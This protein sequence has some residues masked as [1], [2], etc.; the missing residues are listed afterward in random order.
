VS[1]FQATQSS[2]V[3]Q[4][5]QVRCRIWPAMTSMDFVNPLGTRGHLQTYASDQ[6]PSLAIALGVRQEIQSCKTNPRRRQHFWKV[7]IAICRYHWIDS[8]YVTVCQLLFQ[9]YLV[10]IYHDWIYVNYC[11]LTWQLFSSG[12]HIPMRKN[13]GSPARTEREGSSTQTCSI[14][15]R[16]GFVHFGTWKS[17]ENLQITGFSIG[18]SSYE[19]SFPLKWPWI[20][21]NIRNL[22]FFLSIMFPSCHFRRHTLFLDE[23]I[24]NVM[25][26][27]TLLGVPFMKMCVSD[28]WVLTGATR[29]Q[30]PSR[31]QLSK[32][33][34]W[35][36]HVCPRG[37][38]KHVN[39]D[40]QKIKPNWNTIQFERCP[41]TLW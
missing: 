38:P 23:A 41:F 28:F 40:R 3:H 36:S 25:T 11:Q 21:W 15:W 6:A 24:W 27:L 32:E 31:P 7:V 8:K 19:S 39:V 9:S 33:N 34:Q 26:F 14:S 30:Y 35:T 5:H 17:L 29:D 16:L 2:W 1:Y 37:T 4:V 12:W 20:G 18:L 22:P 10:S 13:W